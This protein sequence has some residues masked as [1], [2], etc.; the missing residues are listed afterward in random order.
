MNVAECFELLPRSG[1]EAFDLG[2]FFGA[3][4]GIAGR[5]LAHPCLEHGNELSCFARQLIKKVFG[6]IGIVHEVVELVEISFGVRD[7]D[8]LP[9]FGAHHAP[10]PRLPSK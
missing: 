9:P 4:I 1:V 2:I 8:E 7:A 3:S 6:F 10:L 5:I